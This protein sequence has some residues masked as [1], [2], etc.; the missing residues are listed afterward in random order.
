M[1]P[2][3]YQ[4]DLKQDFTIT[5]KPSRTYR[6][7]F[8]G[9]ASTGMLNGLEAMKQAIF[10]ILSSERYI[11]AIF[12]WNYGVELI[13]LS[14]ETDLALLQSKLQDSITEALMQDDRVLSVFDFNFERI[15]EKRLAVTFT[16]ST[17]EGDVP[18][19]V[20]WQGN[21]LEVNL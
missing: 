4:D 3:A 9:A 5:S 16:V 12:S 19:E 20:E 15:D 18:S 6:L 13:K 14:E 2:S 10:L 1:I 11:Y 7:N 21:G 8:S 17:T